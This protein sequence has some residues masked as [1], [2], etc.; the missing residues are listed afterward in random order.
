MSKSKEK[1]LM[2]HILEIRLTNRMFSFVD[3]KGKMMDSLVKVFG[4]TNFKLR[5]DGARF[6]LATDDLMKSFFF[7]YENFGFQLDATED[8]DTFKR[9]AEDFFRKLNGNTYYT[10]TDGLLRV[11]TKSEIFYHKTGESLE[12]VKEVF[13]NKFTP[14]KSELQTDTGSAI[15]DVAYHFDFTVPTGNANVTLGPTSKEEALQKFFSEKVKL[16][17]KKFDTSNAYTFVIDIANTQKLDIDNWNSLEKRV[18]TQ[19][20]DIEKLYDGMKVFLFK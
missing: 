8:F 20:S 12:K 1:I 7:S 10:W 9:Q 4:A 19:I 5:N 17:E 14:Y 18:V 13:N 11:G 3:N 16:Y 15:T 6:D 2:R